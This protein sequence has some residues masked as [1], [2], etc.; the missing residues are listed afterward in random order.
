MKPVRS[1]SVEH[2]SLRINGQNQ[3]TDASGVPTA[4]FPWPGG[5]EG[6]DLKARFVGGSEITIA[7]QPGL[8]GIWHF[9]DWGKEVRPNEFEWI[10]MSGSVP[11]RT[12]LGDPVAVSFTLDPAKAQVLRPH[13]F[14]LTCISKALQ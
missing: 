12:S 2:V 6:L 3:N 7:H 8:W 10:L 4:E 5:K 1:A 14:S 13:Y 9:L 11:A